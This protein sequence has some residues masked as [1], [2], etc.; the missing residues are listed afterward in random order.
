MKT[1]LLISAFSLLLSLPLVSVGQEQWPRE[2][3]NKSNGRIT[4]YQP[5]PES[6]NEGVLVARSAVSVRKTSNAEP[7]FG[8]VWIEGILRANQNRNTYTLE[9]VKVHDA[10]FPDTED[11]NFVAA[12]K[13]NVA[14]EVAMWPEFMPIDQLNS[15]LNNEKEIATNALNN[16]APTIIF[17][18]K[19]T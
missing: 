18:E 9:N 17:T 11:A 13:S 19:P 15:L 12:I 14:N 3:S 16:E 1:R 5:Q 10:R 6:L 7:V 8:V 4:I 2:L